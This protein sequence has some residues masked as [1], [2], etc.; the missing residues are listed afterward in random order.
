MPVASSLSPSRGLRRV[1]DARPGGSAARRPELH[2]VQ[3]AAREEV[4]PAAGAA[5]LRHE[6]HHLLL[7]GRGHVQHHEEDALLLLAGE[8]P[9]EAALLPPFHGPQ[10][11]RHGVQPVYGG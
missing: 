8:E 2:A 5:Q 11:E 3:R 9:G 6:P 4:V 1:L 10:P 7:Q